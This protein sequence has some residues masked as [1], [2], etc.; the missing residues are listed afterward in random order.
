MPTGDTIW[1]AKENAMLKELFSSTISVKEIAK[2]LG[3]TEGS[4]RTHANSMGLKRERITY[5]GCTEDCFN[6]PY[7]DCMK[8][9]GFSQSY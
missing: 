6:C 7:P 9:G 3:R 2:R 8:Q 4:V 5:S 1:T